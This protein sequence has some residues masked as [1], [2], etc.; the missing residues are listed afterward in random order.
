MRYG[1]SHPSVGQFRGLS[2]SCLRGT[3]L[4]VDPSLAF[5]FSPCSLPVSLG[6]LQV[7]QLYPSSSGS[8]SREPPNKKPL[9]TICL[10]LHYYYCCSL[11]PPHKELYTKPSVGFTLDFVFL[12]PLKFIF[13][14]TFSPEILFLSIFSFDY[15]HFPFFPPHWNFNSINPSRS[16][17][18]STV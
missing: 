8:A 18:P 7:S 4:L 16:F 5:L 2:P 9:A 6:T 3:H 1:A 10:A 17:F 11:M 14:F 13:L 12:E 15:T